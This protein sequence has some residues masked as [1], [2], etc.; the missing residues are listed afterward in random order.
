MNEGKCSKCGSLLMESCSASSGSV[1]SN[2]YCDLRIQPALSKKVKRRNH[3][4]LAGIPECY[5]SG[6]YMRLPDDNSRYEKVR[7]IPGFSIP[8]PS[9]KK[10]GLFGSQLLEL[11]EVRE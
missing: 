7:V 2:I 4:L 6:G 8:R 1:C 9:D 10:M 11:K 3:C 5:E